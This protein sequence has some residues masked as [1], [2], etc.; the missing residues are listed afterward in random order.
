MF[1]TEI[2]PGTK[3]DRLAFGLEWRAYASK[4]AKE[5][6]R[7]YARE[8]YSTHYVEYP[9]G[10]ETIAGFA[11]AEKPIGFRERIYSA[12]ARIASLDRIRGQDAVLILIEDEGDVFV[13]FSVRGTVRLDEVSTPEGAL[14]TRIEIE[15]QCR[16]NGWKLQVLGQG[17]LPGAVD[18]EFNISELAKDRNL[19]KLSKVSKDVPRLVSIS[20]IVVAVVWGWQYL[21]DLVNPPPPPVKRETYMDQYKAVYKKT[22]SVRPPLASSLAPE[23]LGQYGKIEAIAKGWQ[24]DTA[25]CAPVD[26]CKVTWMRE[27]GTYADFDAVAPPSWYPIDYSMDGRTLVTR[28]PTVSRS[29][30]RGID[31]TQH[32]PTWSEFKKV[33]VIP[34]QRLSTKPTQIDSFGYKV[35]LHEP[36]DLVGHPPPLTQRLSQPT[37]K[38]GDFMIEGYRWQTRLLEAL[39]TNMV[40]KKMTIKLGNGGVK[41]IAEGSF[42]V[43]N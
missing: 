6:R 42:Y 5:E 32:W 33:V 43:V 16:K 20:I 22:F 13:V 38:V 26:Q 3:H 4:V 31:A 12:A 29:S 18:E 35:T 10:S 7:R 21:S 27:G 41:F 14:A 39:P 17:M 2:I 28:G 37:V 15:A 8:L 24:F 11:N 40:L 23:L 34:E 1:I 30:M 9:M 25:I 19:G 36:V